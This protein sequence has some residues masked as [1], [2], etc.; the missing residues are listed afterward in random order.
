MK[1]RPAATKLAVLT[2]VFLLFFTLIVLTR[3]NHT[4]I[5]CLGD[6]NTFG[7]GLPLEQSYPAILARQSGSNLHVFNYGVGGDRVSDA[8]KRSFQTVTGHGVKSIVV[9]QIGTNDAGVGTPAEEIYKNIVN[10]LILPLKEKGYEVW[11]VT[12]P[13]RTD[14]PAALDIIKSLNSLILEDRNA[15]VIIDFYAETVDKNGIPQ[16]SFLLSDGLHLTEKATE[17]LANLITCQLNYS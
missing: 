7:S 6:S 1:K 9:I 14:N 17:I 13:V 15:D 12:V 3:N 11:L 16:D 5:I 4:N 2:I 8:A 10:S